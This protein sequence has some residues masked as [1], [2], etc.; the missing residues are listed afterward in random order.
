M[1]C[2]L[3]KYQGRRTNNRSGNL[4]TYLTSFI[5][6]VFA[7]VSSRGDYPMLE[8]LQEG[9]QFLLSFMGGHISYTH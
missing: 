3:F 8:Y 9:K 7:D 4:L 5:Y 6:F 1:S 2:Q